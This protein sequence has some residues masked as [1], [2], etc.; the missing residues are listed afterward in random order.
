VGRTGTDPD[1]QR[2]AAQAEAVIGERTAFDDYLARLFRWLVAASR[3]GR[4]L[5]RDPDAIWALMPAWAESM[6]EFV[7]TA[8]AKLIGTAYRKLLGPGY[9]YSQQPHVTAYLAQAQNRLV[10]VPNQVYDLIVE[11]VAEG[12][13]MG[14][15]IEGIRKRVQETFS[16]TDTPWAN[17]RL[18]VACTETWQPNGAG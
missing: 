8:I 18:P 7:H 1:A 15:G 10:D 4:N 11:Q 17:R 14:E 2:L 13:G 12:A 3:C 6:T 16:L 9:L 5:H